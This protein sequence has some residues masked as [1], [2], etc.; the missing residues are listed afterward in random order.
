LYD[1]KCL[2][3][4]DQRIIREDWKTIST[5]LQDGKAHELSEGDTLYLGACTKAATAKNR[6]TQ[7]G[8][9]PAKPRAYSYKSG[10]M[11]QLVR[12]ELGTVDTDSEKVIKGEEFN[13]EATFQEQVIAKFEPFIGK[14]TAQIESILGAGL[15]FDSKQYFAT[16]ATRMMGVKKKRIEEFESAG[17]KMKTVQ[18]KQSGVPKEDMSF[19]TFQYEELI[20]ETWDADEELGES[21]ALLQQ[22]L[23]RKF[24]FVVFECEKK[25]EKREARKLKQVFF[26]SVPHADRLEAKKVWEE[27]VELV[28]VGKIVERVS[29]NK[30]GD[31]LRKSFFPTSTDT[32]VAHV[33]PHAKNSADVYPLPV[34]DIHTGVDS[35]TKHCFWF[36]KEYI[37]KV[38]KQHV[39]EEAFIASPYT[40]AVKTVKVPLYDSI[41]CGE[42]MYADSISEEDVEVPEWIIRPGA[43]YFA[44]RT[45][46]DSMNKLGIDDGDIILCQ[47]NYQAS[48]GSNAVVLIGED[49]TLKK[50][51]YEKNGLVLLPQSTNP[52]HQIRKLT[53]DDEEFKVLGVF[54]CKL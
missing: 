39:Q 1:F 19:P 24:L 15:N 54:V 40:D 12:R 17:V 50:I 37:H 32:K 7:I 28:K 35:Y 25:C 3:K 9:I 16:L 5:K 29:Y 26:W 8:G 44:L 33:R 21:P 10:Y 47:K 20:K 11:T 4:E 38:I 14:T 30:K 36:N 42:Q 41:G 27:T 2:P 43:K 46:G 22:Y 53:E 51:K 13:K 49:A 23:E 48:S 18:V 34:P 52:S 6:R 45:R 31:K